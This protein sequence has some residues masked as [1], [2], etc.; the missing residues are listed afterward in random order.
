MHARV[1]DDNDDDDD[2]G[3]CYLLDRIETRKT[4][5]IGRDVNI[6]VWG[7]LLD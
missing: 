3:F 7:S 6:R 4:T 2:D 1:D 5:S